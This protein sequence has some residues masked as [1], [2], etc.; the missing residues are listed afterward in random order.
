M[1]EADGQAEGEGEGTEGGAG[2]GEEGDDDDEDEAEDGDDAGESDPRPSGDGEHQRR[3]SPATGPDD[4]DHDMEDA[5]PPADP[6]TTSR[7]EEMEMDSSAADVVPPNPLHLAAPPGSLAAG[8]PKLEGSP[9][10]NMVMPPP[11]EL[12]EPEP[13]SQAPVSDVMSLSEPQGTLEISRGADIDNMSESMVAE[14]P[15]TI[16][17]EIPQEAT[18]RDLPPPV[19]PRLDLSKDDALLPPPPDQVGNISTPK[20]EDGPAGSPHESAD[21]P[22]DQEETT[23]DSYPYKPTLNHRDSV[24]TEDSIKPDDSASVTFPLTESGPPSETGAVSTAGIKDAVSAP[25]AEPIV[26]EP[27]DSP[28]KYDRAVPA[29]AEEPDLLGGLIGALDRQ[30]EAYASKDVEK[31]TPSNEQE[32]PEKVPEEPLPE[33]G[34]LAEPEPRTEGGQDTAPAG[35]SPATEEPP[36]A[37]GKEE[38]TGEDG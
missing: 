32:E 24:M 36:K 19:I 4:T 13:S 35:T 17:G 34:K 11:A 2:E 33:A 38:N 9:L 15:S 31:P 6:P 18:E 5:A 20:T 30:Q 21:K 27:I 29:A 7:L 25:A 8:S 10:K 26:E 37:S 12:Q 22:K 23:A 28:S 16:V 14:P 3:V 1:A